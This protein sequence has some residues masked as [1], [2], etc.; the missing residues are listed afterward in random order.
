MHDQRP[1]SEDFRL[2]D[3]A[4]LTTKRKAMLIFLAPGPN[5]PKVMDRQQWSDRL[6]RIAYQTCDQLH[7]KGTIVALVPQ[8]YYDHATPV[9]G[10]WMK[11][12]VFL[13]K[14]IC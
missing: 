13:C 9:A 6:S 1:L 5:D 7:P 2:D 8:P 4:S 14:L 12:I 3:L 10:G 11:R